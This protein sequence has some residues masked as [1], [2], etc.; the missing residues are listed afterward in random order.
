MNDTI[1]DAK[2]LLRECAN[3]VAVPTAL[4]V[5]LDAGGLAQCALYVIHRYVQVLDMGYEDLNE[6]NELY[7][8]LSDL[9]GVHGCGSNDDTLLYYRMRLCA[10]R[11]DLGQ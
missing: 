10:I 11:E 3:L 7:D 6:V 5:R 2:N 9:W 4:R 8:L 1:C